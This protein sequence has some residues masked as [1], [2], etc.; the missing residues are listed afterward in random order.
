MQILKKFKNNLELLLFNKIS[1]LSLQYRKL[2]D[3]LKN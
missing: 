3:Q 1:L 2:I